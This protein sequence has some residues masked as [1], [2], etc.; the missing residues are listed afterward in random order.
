MKICKNIVSIIVTDL[1]SMHCTLWGIAA[2]IV[3]FACNEGRLRVRPE[4]WT[5]QWCCKTPNW[6][7]GGDGGLQRVCTDKVFEETVSSFPFELCHTF[8]FNY[9]ISVYAMQSTLNR[10]K[11]IEIITIINFYLHTWFFCVSPILCWTISTQM[12]KVNWVTNSELHL[13]F[14]QSMVEAYT[15]K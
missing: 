14:E 10:K 5:S 4:G 8:L 2:D 3:M 15:P 13:R 11:K 6:F 9:I 7:F 12:N 1:R